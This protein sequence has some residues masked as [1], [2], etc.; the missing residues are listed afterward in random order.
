[1]G[2]FSWLAEVSPGKLLHQGQPL[3]QHPAT[4]IQ[5]PTPSSGR[6]VFTFEEPGAGGELAWSPDGKRIA[7][8]GDQSRGENTILVW[9]ALTGKNI[10]SLQD[11]KSLAIQAIAWS[12]DGKSIADCQPP[13]HQKSLAIQAIAWS[14][15]GKSIAAGG[16]YPNGDVQIWDAATGKVI[17]KPQA[18]SDSIDSITRPR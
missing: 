12:P 1:M 14:P 5:R 7:C 11:Q 10:V 6:I 18:R 8:T 15:D 9:D 2:G 3:I 13:G 16:N 4:P 17:Q